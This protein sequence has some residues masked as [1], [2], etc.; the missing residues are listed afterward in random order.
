MVQFTPNSAESML[1]ESADKPKSDTIS[2][3]SY[4]KLLAKLFK[5][6]LIELLL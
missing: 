5:S 3:M 4:N 6:F 2:T 1:S